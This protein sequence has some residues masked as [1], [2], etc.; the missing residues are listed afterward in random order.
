MAL[1]NGRMNCGIYESRP[2]ERGRFVMGG[3]IAKRFA[4]TLSNRQGIRRAC[5]TNGCKE[6]PTPPGHRP[7]AHSGLMSSCHVHESKPSCSFDLDDD[8]APGVPRFDVGQGLADR[9]EWEDPIHDGADDPS[10]DKPGDL[11]QLRPIGP[12]E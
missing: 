4:L 3:P 8:L 5:A 9:F 12:H 6:I 11:S 7:S 2:A 1:N 10:L